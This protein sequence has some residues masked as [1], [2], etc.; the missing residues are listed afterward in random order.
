MHVCVS[1]VSQHCKGHDS[2][3]VV[4]VMQQCNFLEALS[5]VECNGRCV[6]VYDMQ[7][8]SE[9]TVLLRLLQDG[10]KQI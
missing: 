6:V 9:A 5:P 4:K 1:I 7:E 3:N 8:N 2:P 10:S